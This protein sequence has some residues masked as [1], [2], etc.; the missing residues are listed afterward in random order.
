M[1]IYILIM[2][3]QIHGVHEGVSS[4]NV[5]PLV[6]TISMNLSCL[7]WSN[8]SNCIVCH[9]HLKIHALLPR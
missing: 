2:H 6:T 8:A 7:S 1:T 3:I 9:L 4:T 5:F